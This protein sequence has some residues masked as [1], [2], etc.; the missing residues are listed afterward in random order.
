MDATRII[1]IQ[2]LRDQIPHQNDQTIQINPKLFQ[3][4]EFRALFQDNF[5]EIQEFNTQYKDGLCIYIFSG[6]EL[7]G[8]AF[9]K[10]KTAEI[11]TLILG[12]HSQSEVFLSQDQSLSLRHLIFMTHPKSD[13][14]IYRILDLRSRSGFENEAGMNC[15]SLI[16]DG[17]GFIRLN[18][19]H[20][21]CFPAQ[22]PSL[23]GNEPQKSW[24]ALPPRQYKDLPSDLNEMSFS[25]HCSIVFSTPP[26]TPL[27]R[28]VTQKPVASLELFSGDN[29]VN[30][31]L[32]SD[33][34]SSGILIGRYTR[35][36]R[37]FQ[38]FLT[39]TSISR[40][41]LL[42][43]EVEG[44]M[45]IIDT[46]STNGTYIDGE[47]IKRMTLDQTTDIY[48]GEKDNHYAEGLKLTFTP[49]RN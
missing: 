36:D 4:V 47:R 35:C 6:Q 14:L 20:I 38:P 27:R 11:N 19:Y 28:V 43:V 40:V 39:I 16:S 37:A 26:P 32:D 13:R 21:L 42:I 48:I 18:H 12:R 23:N 7:I 22:C 1:N 33:M 15:H 44:Q 24:D 5:S 8:K 2:A 29:Y 30:Q 25:E 46:A 45:Y 41:H 9:L 31:P 10:T 3:R 49:I 17:H 34:L